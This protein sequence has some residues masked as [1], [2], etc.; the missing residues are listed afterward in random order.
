EAISLSPLIVSYR[1]VY[2]TARLGG[3]SFE[4]GKGFQYLPKGMKWACLGQGYNYDIKSSQLEILRHELQRIGLSDK[5]L[6]R[7]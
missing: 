1:Q 2:R 6:K 7:L 3:R 5:N 4:V